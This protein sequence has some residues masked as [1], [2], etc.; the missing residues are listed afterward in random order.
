MEANIIFEI[1]SVLDDKKTLKYDEWC[2]WVSY[3]QCNLLYENGNQTKPSSYSIFLDMHVLSPIALSRLYIKY[4][5]SYKSW[6]PLKMVIFYNFGNIFVPALW[7][8]NCMTS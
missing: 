8:H 3:F 2:K 6:Q 4:N 5:K 1:N 7:R